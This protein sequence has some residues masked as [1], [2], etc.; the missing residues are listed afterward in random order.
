[1]TNQVHILI[2]V[3]AERVEAALGLVPDFIR[4][5]DSRPLR[6]QIHER[7]VYG[8]WSPIKGFKMDERF[9]LSYP[10]DPALVPY[11]FI[12]HGDERLY[13]YQS[14]IFAIVQKDGTFEVARLD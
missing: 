9:R 6:E 13:A 1:M 2:P 3:P 4:Q 8:G 12:E 14:S 5:D 10:G 11:C 7:Y